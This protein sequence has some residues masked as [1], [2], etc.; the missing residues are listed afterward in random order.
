[1]KTFSASDFTE[2]Q[3]E[4]LSLDIGLMSSIEDDCKVNVN[5]KIDIPPV[6]ISMGEYDN[7]FSDTTEVLPV[8][9]G[10]YG[11]FSFIQAPPKSKKTFLI[12]LMT[13]VYLSGEN[14]FG[15]KMKGHRG[16]KKLVHFDTEQGK[17]HAQA[18]FRRPT[19]MTSN[20]DKRDYECYALRVIGFRERIA[21]IEYKLKE[22][23]EVGEVGLVV[24]DG[25]ADLVSDV[26]NLQEANDCVQ[27]LME[28]TAK[29]S[30]HIITVIHSNYGSEKPTG[31]LGS[32]LEKKAET[33]INL[34]K[35]VV[36]TDQITVKCKRSRNRGFEKFSFKVNNIGL[37]EVIEDDLDLF[38]FREDDNKK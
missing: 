7:H 29:Y 13:S 36:N 34:E 37:P 16:K 26:N 38:N 18:V 28:W 11:N 23:S 27:K 12:S 8:P 1:L 14:N 25:I 6:A 35:N 24:V 19:R 2:I 15:W 4:D 9:I 21:F 32:L 20:F 31:H 33:Q 30:C 5:D 22:I 3:A 17:Y 10:T